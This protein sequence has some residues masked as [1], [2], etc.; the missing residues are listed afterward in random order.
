MG[1]FD[2]FKKKTEGKVS[3]STKKKLTAIDNDIDDI[4]A[5]AP[6][7]EEADDLRSVELL[8]KKMEGFNL[9]QEE[10]DWVEAY[11]KKEK[12]RKEEERKE[13]EKIG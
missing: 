11:D 3:E 6:T 8:M 1:L 4:I 13:K 2:I 5:S 12:E 7:S 9:T 10:K